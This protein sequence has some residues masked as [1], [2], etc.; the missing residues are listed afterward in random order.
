MN[1]SGMEKKY[2]FSKNGDINYHQYFMKDTG[3]I[4]FSNDG[5]YG[6]KIAYEDVS[7]LIIVLSNFNVTALVTK[8]KQKELCIDTTENTF[9]MSTNN[10]ILLEDGI[11]ISSQHNNVVPYDEIERFIFILKFI[12]RT[13]SHGWNIHHTTK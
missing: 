8:V 13:R 7:Q 5:R 4:R 11:A 1:T 6:L 10:V 12:I 3:Y 2:Y 9:H